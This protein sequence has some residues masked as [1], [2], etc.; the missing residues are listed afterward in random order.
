MT[1][2]VLICDERPLVG[3]GLT[4]LLR[5]EPD[6]Q[7][8]GC[9]D[10]E[11]L[12]LDLLRTTSPDVLLAGMCHGGT[13]GLDFV[14]RVMSGDGREAA[15]VV[16]TPGTKPDD[17]VD[18]ILRAGAAGV[19]AAG[20][21]REELLMAIRAVARGQA[22]L[23]P[24]VARRLVDWYRAKGG[25]SAEDAARR[26]PAIDELTTREREVLTLTATGLSAEEAAQRMSIR[27]ATVRTH[28]YRVRCKLQLRDRAQLV[29]YAYQAGL[30]N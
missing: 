17:R 20:A 16:Y 7:V 3:D 13:M 21:C 24:T 30:M 2:N 4:D 1:L 15:V 25:P 11:P 18:D 8:V 12:A 27:L 9:A 23:S 29:T 19:L 26:D 10:T 28:L 14:R 6:M 22:M 5:T